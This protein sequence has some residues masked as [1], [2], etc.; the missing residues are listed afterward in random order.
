V[1]LVNEVRAASKDRDLTFAKKLPTQ[2]EASEVSPSAV[3]YLMKII[4]VN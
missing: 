4:G 2:F 3:Q 1:A